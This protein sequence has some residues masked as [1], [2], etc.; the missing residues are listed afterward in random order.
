MWAEIL[1]SELLVGS[2]PNARPKIRMGKRATDSPDRRVDVPCFYLFCGRFRVASL[3]DV[4]TMCACKVESS[5]FEIRGVP[6]ELLAK[7]SQRSRQRDA[8]IAAF[9]ERHGRKP[10]LDRSNNCGRSD[11][12]AAQIEPQTAGAEPLLAFAWT[13]DS[14]GTKFPPRLWNRP[15]KTKHGRVVY[16]RGD[17][18]TARHILLPGA[19]GVL[20]HARSSLPWVVVGLGP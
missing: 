18:L 19:G 9:V 10:T 17:V 15:G 13:H 16:R 5:G 11:S 1:T 4:C 20:R 3:I 12:A 8:T 6:Q 2:P 7:F 14:W